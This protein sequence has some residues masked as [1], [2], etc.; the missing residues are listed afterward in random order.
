MKINKS[1]IKLFLL[2]ALSLILV[3]L[4]IQ[5]FFFGILFFIKGIWFNEILYFSF[6]STFV[7][8]IYLVFRYYFRGRIYDKLMLKSPHL[9]DY[10]IHHPRGRYE[11]QF[12]TMM[13]QFI[14]VHGQQKMK[15]KKEKALQKVLIYRFVHQMK[16]PVSVIKLISEDQHHSDFSVINNNL[17]S[18][19]YH[20]DQMLNMYKLDDFKNDFVAE[21]VHLKTLCKDS[22]NHLKDYFISFQVFPKLEIDAHV[23]VYSD[24]KWLKIVIHQ[25]LTNA[26]KYSQSGAAVTLRCTYK[27]DKILL[28][29][30][31]E[32]IGITPSE[33]KK[34]FDLFYVG[35]NGRNNADSSGIGLYIA[36]TIIDYLDHDITIQSQI[37][38]GT[39]VT[40]HF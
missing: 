21:K 18:I 26:I 35:T 11:K 22:I 34:V 2:D 13:H 6:L 29:I 7:L 25:L 28:S 19:Q 12:N 15:Y 36:R 3:T 32:G 4:I 14:H 10:L 40:I 16:T 8:F 17:H 9:N 23:Y 31:D 5:I 1:A 33:I 24:S 30:I 20:L 37:G 27:D 39:S 38:E